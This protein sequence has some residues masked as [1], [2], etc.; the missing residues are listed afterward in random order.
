MYRND[1]C[2]RDSRNGKYLHNLAANRLIAEVVNT[3]QPITVSEKIIMTCLQFSPPSGRTDNI[4]GGTHNA[5]IGGYQQ[6]GKKQQ[7]AQRRYCFR[8]WRQREA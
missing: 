2:T 4:V 1:A 8:F 6:D 7:S 3:P 5:Q